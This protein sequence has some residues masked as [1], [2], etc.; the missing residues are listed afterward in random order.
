MWEVNII[1][2]ESIGSSL[3]MKGFKRECLKIMDLC[4]KILYD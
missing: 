1:Y 2:F 3:G 4:R